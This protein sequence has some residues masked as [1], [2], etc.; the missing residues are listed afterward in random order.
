MAATQ[1]VAGYVFKR[2]PIGNDNR[3][4]FRLPAYRLV[5]WHCRPRDRHT[6]RLEALLDRGI[7]RWFHHVL[8]LLQR[9]FDAASRPSAVASDCLYGRKRL[10]RY[11]RSLCRPAN[12]QIVLTEYRLSSLSFHHNV[13]RSHS[14]SAQFTFLFL[15][16]FSF[17]ILSFALIALLLHSEHEK[18]IRK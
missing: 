1:A 8:H 4:P 9:E 18:S 10:L 13:P 14:F 15:S 11:H 12:Y 16:F 2:L 17:Q 6:G 7:L 3:Q 5:L